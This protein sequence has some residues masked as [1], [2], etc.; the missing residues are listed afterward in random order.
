[1]KLGRNCNDDTGA[2]LNQQHV[3][4]GRSIC[5]T[6]FVLRRGKVPT[7]AI[8]SEGSISNSWTVD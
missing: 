3:V 5:G 7:T 8:Q 1:M 2:K 4:V 6:V